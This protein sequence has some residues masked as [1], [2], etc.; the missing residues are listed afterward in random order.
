MKNQPENQN[1]I[2]TYMDVH[3][4]PLGNRAFQPDTIKN[5]RTIIHSIKQSKKMK[6]L[7]KPHN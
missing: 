5:I 3:N 7:P 2:E 1:N 6:T 4:I